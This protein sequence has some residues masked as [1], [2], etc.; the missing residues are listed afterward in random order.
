MHLSTLWLGKPHL[1]PPER[2]V[3]IC[4]C[5]VVNDQAIRAAVDAGATTLPA[6]SRATGAGTGCGG[7]VWSVK[8]ILCESD[9]AR[10]VMIP[11]VPRAAQEPA[12]R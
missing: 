2:A 7:C 6:V 10:S 11:E 4:H 8:M 12:S 9:S 1:L 3:I 5:R